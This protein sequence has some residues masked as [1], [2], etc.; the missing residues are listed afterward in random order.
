MRFGNLIMKLVYQK[1]LNQFV[2][3][4]S[5]GIL[6]SSTHSI[7]RLLSHVAQLQEAEGLV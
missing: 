3:I 1:C 5:R 6:T 2:I 4:L 7:T